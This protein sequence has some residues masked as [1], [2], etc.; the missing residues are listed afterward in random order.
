MIRYLQVKVRNTTN[1]EFFLVCIFLNLDSI[2]R[3]TDYTSVFSP[4]T[5][6]YGPEITPYLSTFH[7]VSTAQKVNALHK[8]LNFSLRIFSE[9][10]SKTLMQMSIL[11]FC[12]VM[13]AYI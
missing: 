5:G 6:K 12:A 8:K 11:I 3:F 7:V 1:M 13:P 9:N 4:N 2:R 10:M